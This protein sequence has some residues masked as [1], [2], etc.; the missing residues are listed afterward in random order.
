MNIVDKILLMVDLSTIIHW[1][2]SSVQCGRCGHLSH[3]IIDV[4]DIWTAEQGDT[5][6]CQSQP[7]DKPRPDMSA[8]FDNVDNGEQQWLRC[9][10][11][12]KYLGCQDMVAPWSMNVGPINNVCM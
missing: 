4:L 8:V 12:S 2:P 3:Y 7:S 6:A 11:I 10:D 9:R 5:A 1:L